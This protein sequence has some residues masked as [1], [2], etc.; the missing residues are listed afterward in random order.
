MSINK[1]G[2]DFLADLGACKGLSRQRVARVGSVTKVTQTADWLLVPAHV[3]P[4]TSDPLEHLQFAL[5]H[6]GM[7]M[8]AAIIALKNIEAQA[9][10]QFFQGSP[11]GSY[12]KQIAYL[13]E[14]ANEKTL[15]DLPAAMG[16]YVSLFDPKDFV[17]GD[18]QKNARWRVDFNGIGSPRYCPSVRR[19][20]KLLSYLEKDILHEAREF[21][22]GLDQIT[23]DRAVRW[24]YLS[25]TEGSYAIERELP[26]PSKSEAF[27]SLLAK[28]HIPEKITEKYLI[29]LQNLAINNPLDKA[30]Q[31]RNE[32]NWLR[33]ESKGALG[34]TYVP[35]DPDLMYD[36]MGDVMAL[37]NSNTTT[38]DPL[39]RA[40]L[41]SFAFV[42]AHPFMDGNGRLSRLLFHKVLCS[43][44]AMPDGL[45]LPVSIAM[46]RN[47][48]DYLL[49]LQSFSKP[50][51]DLW[52]V[53]AIDECRFDLTFNG[54]PAIY[55]Y[56]DAT[57][58]VTFGLRM[59]QTALQEDLRE[60]SEFIRRF[61]LA[62]K[63]ANDVADMN[64]ND[65]TLLVRSVIQN[66]M[67]LSKNRRKQ[68][69]AKGH[70]PTIIDSIE[71]AITD[72]L[73]DQY[74]QD[75]GSGHHSKAP[76]G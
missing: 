48:M 41:V 50:S 25:E 61:D 65:L 69:L 29:Q 11:T 14:I 33:N 17:T 75:E 31:F 52:S 36:L 3:A 46:R 71:A 8:Q 21:I 4:Q 53:L 60:E 62:Y 72:A 45:V 34:V 19:T 73:A 10:G 9:V 44:G 59:A 27:S 66:D 2:Y 42:F 15:P 28:A 22:S 12:A 63:A 74:G 18:S 5:K 68:L 37:A 43:T 70:P 64:N 23:L 57:E 67:G 49:A 39:I 32:K 1:I 13:W 16:P 35:P 7:D 55:R 30:V 56:W 47:E 54:D 6:E 20:P 24:A 40:S 58:C 76:R 38:V 26:N 51:R